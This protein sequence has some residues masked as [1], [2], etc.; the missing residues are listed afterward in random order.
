MTLPADPHAL[1][2]RCAELMME[3]DEATRSLGIEL[4]DIGPGRARMEMDVTRAMLNGHG[5]CHGGVIFT[6]ADSA[7]AFACNSRGDRA[8]AFQCA[9]TFL[10]PGRCGD[11]LVATAEERASA[12]RT[13]LY[14]VRVA[15]S[16]GRLVAEFRG[17]SRTIG[18]FADAPG[19][20]SGP[21]AA[22][23]QT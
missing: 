14:D 20:A 5:A 17:C 11:R 19:G 6:L 3:G 15:T 23:A 7:F 10:A 13:G 18:S 16:D 9:V 4:A 22:T 1:A 8:V 2:R 12:G 21:D